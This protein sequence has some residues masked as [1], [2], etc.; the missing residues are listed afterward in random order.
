MNILNDLSKI[1]KLDKSNVL[2][3]VDAL[4]E[5]CLHAWNDVEKIKLD[6]NYSK[7]NKIIVCGMGGSALGPHVIQS[8]FDI[9]VPLFINRDYDLPS[10]TDKQTLV[11]LSSYSGNTEEVISCTEKSIKKE[12]NLLAISTGG[13]LLK[14]CQDENIPFYKIIPKYNPS[15]QPRMAIGYSIFGQLALLTK[16]GFL[17][18]NKEDVISLVEFLKK[19]KKNIEPKKI[20]QEIDGKIPILIAGR[21]LNGS[22]HVFNNQINENSKN[23]SAFFYLPELNHHLMEGLS[24]PKINSENL[25]FI[26][27]DSL[28]YK[29]RVRQRLAITRQVLKK[30]KIQSL[31]IELKGKTKLQQGFEAILIGSYVNFYLAMLNNINPAPIPWVDYF[32]KE[33]KKLPNEKR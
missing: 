15:N 2:G 26:C 13:Q 23:F 29:L 22:I 12:L 14:I 31:T 5:Q 33:L 6:K 9:K 3:S 1:E 7:I 28:L 27:F 19:T 17:K 18:I 20:A 25:I 4:P 11:I 8:I 24:F 30:N 10:W 21:H 16:T 32:K